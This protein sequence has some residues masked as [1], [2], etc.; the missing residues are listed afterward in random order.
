M[1]LADERHPFLPL[2]LRHVY[3]MVATARPVHTGDRDILRLQNLDWDSSSSG[4]SYDS[5]VSRF[6]IEDAGG[7]THVDTDRGTNHAHTH[8]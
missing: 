8:I 6:R 3:I 2:S 4:V 5:V 7:M 1:F